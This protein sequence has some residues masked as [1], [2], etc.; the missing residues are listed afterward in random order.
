MRLF[1]GKIPREMEFTH[2]ENFLLIS[3]KN[4]LILRMSREEKQFFFLTE[5][6]ISQRDIFLNQRVRINRICKYL[7][8][9][10]SVIHPGNEMVFLSS[11][12][13]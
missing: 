4:L 11:Q 3:S 10:T 6:N 2:Y 12:L 5:I 13:T 1:N 7:P 8:Q 9:N